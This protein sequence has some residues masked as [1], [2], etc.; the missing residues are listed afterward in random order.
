VYS[1]GDVLG[2]TEDSYDLAGDRGYDKWLDWPKN[3]LD[4]TDGSCAIIGVGDGLVD[5]LY[6]RCARSCDPVNS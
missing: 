6:A 1:P 3:L 5:K 4:W 2:D